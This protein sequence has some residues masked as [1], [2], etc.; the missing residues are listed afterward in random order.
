MFSFVAMG[1][2]VIDA[3][4]SGLPSSVTRPETW[5]TEYGLLLQPHNTARRSKVINRG[6]ITEALTPAGPRGPLPLT[7]G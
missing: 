4:G 3:F 7:A 1:T 2:K 6:C 5:A